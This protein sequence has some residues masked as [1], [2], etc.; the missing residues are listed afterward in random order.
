MHS[1]LGRLGRHHSTAAAY[2]ALILALGGTAYAAATI[3]SEDIV[4]ETI[5]SQDIAA[6][7]VGTDEI[8]TEAVTLDRLHGGSVT[9][10]KVADGTL[11]GVDVRNGSLSGHDVADGSLASSDIADRSLKA[12]D[13]DVTTVSATSAREPGSQKT[14]GVYCAY[15]KTAVGGGGM[16]SGV[17]FGSAAITE[18]V[19][20]GRGWRVTAEL[21]DYPAVPEWEFSYDGDYITGYEWWSKVNDFTY[22]GD[23]ALQAW[24]VCV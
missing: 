5:Q 6:Q 23:W 24:A 10:T 13:L 11:W 18:S 14:K 1:P 22:R 15:G 17:P 4:D 9:G 20:D 8:G 7:A 19:P 3:T 16:I 21:N 12:E 2:A